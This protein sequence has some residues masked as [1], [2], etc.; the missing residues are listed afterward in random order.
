[1]TGDAIG[2]KLQCNYARHADILWPSHD[3][4]GT[5]EVDYSAK[6]EAAKHTFT[7]TPSQKSEVK[8]FRIYDSTQVDFIPL[9]LATEF[10]NLNG[11]KFSYCNLPTV[12][13]GFFKQELQNIEFLDLAVNEIKV[14]EPKAFQYL[15]KLKYINL[16]S[17]NLQT[18][19]DQLFQNSPDLIYIDLLQNQINAIVPN[20]FDGLNKLKL[21]YFQGNL[22]IDAEIGCETCLITQLELKEKLQ[23]CFGNCLNDTNCQNSQLTQKAS[24]NGDGTEGQ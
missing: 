11:V 16:F 9:E 2:R 20:F 5:N 6:F 22:C 18:L 21:M 19:P 23:G 8:T 10:P 15:I 12:K 1:M 24:E 14:I 4:C 7:G 13:E 17:N 3:L